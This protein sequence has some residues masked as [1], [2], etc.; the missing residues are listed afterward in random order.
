MRK[1]KTKYN[2][3]PSAMLL[4]EKLLK[5]VAEERKC[6]FISTGMSTMKEIEKSSLEFFR[7]SKMSI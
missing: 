1:F 2:K 3:I 4:H 6:T 5:T 7:K